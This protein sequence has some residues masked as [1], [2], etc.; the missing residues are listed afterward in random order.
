MSKLIPK[1][2]IDLLHSEK[3]VAVGLLVIAATVMVFTGH[4][5]IDEWLEYTQVLA[6]TFVTGKTI[7]GAASEMRRGSEAK[8]E[9]EKL[10][11]GVASND[12]KADA[13]AAKL[14]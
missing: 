11:A 7:Q 13:A 10:K 9:A 1:A 12:A 14:P 8:A 5:T 6:I 2:I 3:A 4:L